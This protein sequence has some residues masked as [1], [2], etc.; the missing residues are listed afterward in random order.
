MVVSLPSGIRRCGAIGITRVIDPLSRERR[1]RRCDFSRVA[2]R[3]DE[4]IVYEEPSGQ[5]TPAFEGMTLAVGTT[6]ERR[7]HGI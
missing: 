4:L 3:T 2:G 5:L 6:N 1:P 7:S